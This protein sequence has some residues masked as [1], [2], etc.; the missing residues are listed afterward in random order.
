[1]RSL[2]AGADPVITGRLEP[3]ALAASGCAHVSVVPTQLR[4]MLDAGD[5]LTAAKTILLGGAAAP[6][7]PA[8]RGAGGGRPGHHHLRNERNQRR[9]RV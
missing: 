1:M 2:L 4:R 8:G 7:G 9:M 6:A 3:G 5:D